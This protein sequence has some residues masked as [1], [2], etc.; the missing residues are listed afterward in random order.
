[1]RLLARLTIGSVA[2][3]LSS[4]GGDTAPKNPLV[5]TWDLTTVNNVA[6]PADISILGY[7]ARVVHRTI[8]VWE[9]GTAIWSD[10]SLN[11]LT[12]IPPSKTGPM[13]NASGGA[14]GTW[15]ATGI[16]SFVF[17]RNAA[18]TAGYVVSPK[19][20][21]L[22]ADGTLLKTDDSQSESYKRRP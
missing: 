22:Q 15:S 2:A 18:T 4:C 3:L 11:A 8:D 9:N 19:T 7:P 1:M 5:G 12:C 21:V 17:A 20:F 13:C 14:S 6:V 10:S 16:V